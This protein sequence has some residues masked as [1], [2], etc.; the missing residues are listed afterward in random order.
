MC[1]WTQTD[2]DETKIKERDTTTDMATINIR[3]EEM[4]R[5]ATVRSPF[6]HDSSYLLWLQINLNTIN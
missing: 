4:V 1:V 6:S 5:G 3:T 2:S